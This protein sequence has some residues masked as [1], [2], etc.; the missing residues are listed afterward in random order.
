MQRTRQLRRNSCGKLGR[1]ETPDEIII[2]ESAYA[3]ALTIGFSKGR[4]T[5]GY[6]SELF[7]GRRLVVGI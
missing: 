4:P 3:F 7:L 2:P 6:Q 5:H 1:P